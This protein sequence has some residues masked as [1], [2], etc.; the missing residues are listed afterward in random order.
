MLLF[1]TSLGVIADSWPRAQTKEVFS[2]SREYFV[3]IIPGAS[4]GETVGFAGA[5]KGKHATAEFYRREADK[6][7]KLI[8]QIILLNPVA[9]VEFFVSNHGQLVTLD[10]WH[11]VGYGKVVALYD[12]Q[13]RAIQSYELRDL[14]QPEEIEKL[15]HS[16]SSI[17]WRNGPAYIRA[18]HKTFLV[19]VKNG[20]D[21]LFGLESGRYKYCEYHGKN[22]RCRTQN[23][24]RVWE[25]NAKTELIR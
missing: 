24:P 9:P 17:H 3:R 7:Y 22:Y 16:V 5:E 14:F 11:N 25:P 6:S 10:N 2:E 8:T 18:D 20:A 13:G 4:I 12:A 15:S 19:T 1:V 21:F 23:Q